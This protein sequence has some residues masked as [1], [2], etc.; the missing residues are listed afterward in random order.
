M[1]MKTAV[2][3]ILSACV[4]SATVAMT[5]TVAPSEYKGIRQ[6]ADD[7]KPED[8]VPPGMIFIP[9]STFETGLDEEDIQELGLEVDAEIKLF[10]ASVPRHEVSV[11]PYYLGE[12]EITNAQWKVYL[13]AS[14][15]E[16]SADLV[17]GSWTD[18]EIP[19][20]KENYPVTYLSYTQVMDYCR[21]ANVRLPTEHE[22]ERAA[23]GPD[24]ML[25]PWGNEYSEP[26]PKELQRRPR[27]AQEAEELD[28]KREALRQGKDMCWSGEARKREPQEVGTKPEGVSGFGVHDMAGNVWEWTQSPYS[29]YPG[30]K[31]IKI[32]TKVGRGKAQKFRAA[33][34]FNSSRRVIKG[35][36][37]DSEELALRADVRQ[38]ADQGSYFLAIGF[39][40]AKSAI[41]GTE[42]IAYA[43]ESVGSFKFHEKTAPLDLTAVQ[44]VERT[45]YNSDGHITGH[46]GIVFAPV[47]DWAKQKDLKR[48]S[49]ESLKTPVSIGL[50]TMTEESVYPAIPAG[51][52]SVAFQGADKK[53]KPA[54]TF[55]ETPEDDWVFYGW[56]AHDTSVK[57]AEKKTTKK[58]ARKPKKKKRA[59][60]KG[61]A[62]AAEGE[63]GAK[64]E[65]PPELTEEEKAVE[66]HRFRANEGS[67]PYDRRRPNIL[68]QDSNGTVVAALPI[69]N[70]KESSKPLDT[71]LTRNMFPKNARKKLPELE[72][73]KYEW[74]IAFKS[75]R[76]HLKF[77]MPLLF[78]PDAFAR[79]GASAKVNTETTPEDR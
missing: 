52:Y 69:K 33:E 10:A 61:D 42:A 40:I 53:W 9:G 66:K 21:W 19:A 39:R 45:H 58:P 77:E 11:A 56:Q 32:K 75:G 78:N 43:L 5:S 64:E 34:Y 67:V 22:W 74:S 47:S 70:Q 60:K 68:I 50:L 8:R 6:T 1:L 55:E 12:F 3:G 79:E 51:T 38:F 17:E 27:D 57:K 15:Q 25:Y 76:K 46:Q 72:R 16:P 49:V 23:R 29:P 14:E 4:A 54:P 30:E 35:G 13:D 7:A 28:K 18:G 2:F 36:A 63:E 26:I 59:S 41:P 48:A 37:F 65:K 73:Y 44:A 31:E 24:G 20:G 71:A 62:G